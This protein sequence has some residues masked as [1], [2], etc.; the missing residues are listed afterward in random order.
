MWVILCI[1]IYYYICD[2]SGVYKRIICY[3]DDVFVVFFI[4]NCKNLII[5][6]V[7]VV[8]KVFCWSNYWLFMLLYW[9]MLKKDWFVWYMGI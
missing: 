5:I 6:Y 2:K 1:G 8:D 7:L 3:N 9:G 4:I